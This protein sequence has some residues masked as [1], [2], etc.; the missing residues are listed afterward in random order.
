MKFA[1]PTWLFG[2]ALAAL[3]ALLLVLGGFGHQRFLRRF[4]DEKLVEG[5]RTGRTGPRRALRGVFLVL[6]LVLVFVAAAQPQYGRGTRLIPATNLDVVLVLDYSKS[7]YARDVT[8][9]RT[10]R[11][12]AEM[13]HL[14]RQL[15]GARFGAIAFAGEAMSFPLSSDGAAIAQFFRGLEPNDMPI[16][17]TAIAR[18]L[19]SGRQLLDR[20]PK[21][22]QHARVM[23]L[24]TDGED[25]EG[26]PVAVAKSAAKDGITIH[27]VQ[28]GGSE[29]V[30]IPDVDENG[31]SHGMRRD[32][33]GG[34]LTTALSAQG[35][36]TLRE[37]A[38]VGGGDLIR[39]E[40]G[41][42]GLE[43][44]TE[45]LRRQMTEELSERVETVYDDVYTYPLALAVLFLLLEASIGSSARRKPL[46]AEPPP[47]TRRRSL[48]RQRHRRATSASLILLSAPGLFGCD[49]ADRLF[50]RYSPVVDEAV[51]ALKSEK[52]EEA[53]SIL[54]EYLG[55]GACKEGVISVV[56]RV[57]KRP[58]ATFDLGLGFFGEAE[59]L[60]DPFEAPPAASAPGAPPPDP[61]VVEGRKQ[62]IECALRLLSPIAGDGAVPAELRAR[63]HYLIGNLE[64]LRQDYEAAVKAYDA[65][66]TLIPGTPEG[67]GDGLGRDAAHNRAVALRRQQESEKEKEKQEQEQQQS[68]SQDEQ[69]EKPDEGDQQKDERQKPEDQSGSEE[70]QKSDEQKSEGDDADQKPGDQ[71]EGEDGKPRDE[72]GDEKQ[73][74][75]K[76][77]DQAEP[78]Q[79]SD[80]DRS[81]PGAAGSAPPGE[82]GPSASQ[83]DRILDELEHA[84]TFQQHD[85]QQRSRRIRV[86]GTMEDK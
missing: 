67:E 11:A 54:T 24:V 56:D 64:F 62:Q 2:C 15:P 52:S 49:V 28:I 72:S 10:A 43:Q 40:K 8:P 80:E 78:G 14:V 70:D 41:K 82:T 61:A 58:D 12:K 45:R 79:K 25:L 50:E 69:Q 66:L 47:R 83:D 42:T 48:R 18:A 26:D 68:S 44:I 32:S 59:K 13:S 5:L 81:S 23:V 57:R 27:V 46:K 29:P 51:A 22:G 63:A 31:E 20:D 73:E 17:G 76:Q 6:A 74:Q 3:V 36:A 37:I 85:A 9:S 65:S 86:R 16:G 34:I 19:E 7:M 4:G 35:E 53:V 60:G 75:E 77:A 33:Q 84:P 39:P 55:T 71:E 1:E 38:S 21:S 30:P